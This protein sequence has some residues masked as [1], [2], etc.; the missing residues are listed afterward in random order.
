MKNKIIKAKETF[1]KLQD[2]AR[3]HALKERDAVLKEREAKA[4]ECVEHLIDLTIDDLSLR[5]VAYIRG[6][7]DPIVNDCFI[8]GVDVRIVD[9][10]HNEDVDVVYFPSL[11]CI[12]LSFI[13]NKDKCTLV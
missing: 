3:Q 10:L 5:G 8:L 9:I 11:H 13:T 7:S 2:E 12:K 4:K 6:W 1:T